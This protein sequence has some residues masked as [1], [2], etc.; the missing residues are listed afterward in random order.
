MNLCAVDWI[1]WAAW[2]GAGSTFGLLIA[3]VLGF[4]AWKSQFKKQRDHDL[5]IRVLRA[6]SDSYVELDDMRSPTGLISDH[7][8]AI[9]P[10]EFNDPNMD[11]S[12]RVM[13]ARYLARKMHLVSVVKNRT[14]L[15]NEGL[16][17]W[18]GEYGETLADL[19]NELGA[20]ESAVSQQVAI[21]L[22]GLSLRAE[23]DIDYPDR[24]ILYSPAGAEAE[25]QF[26][27][28]YQTKIEAIRKHLAPKI[29]MD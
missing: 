6:V 19:I 21:Y 28:E 9:D 10:P 13:K 18:E 1:A 23:G 12:Y 24:D 17:I 8:V 5:A 27:D 20:M 29:R 14:A 16:V 7:E 11:A 2:I 15:L 4:Y 25:D 26:A 3:A 22:D